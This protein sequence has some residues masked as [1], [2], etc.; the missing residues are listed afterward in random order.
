MG[1]PT[2][3]NA[4]EHARGAAVGLIRVL[5]VLWPAGNA[6]AGVADRGSR[7]RHTD[8]QHRRRGTASPVLSWRPV[9]C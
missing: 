1:R 7:S 2:V 3:Q 8:R 6:M 4:L 5:R 9:W